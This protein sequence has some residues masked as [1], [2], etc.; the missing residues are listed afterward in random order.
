VNF[1]IARIDDNATITMPANGKSVIYLVTTNKTNVTITLPPAASAAGRFVI[2]KRADRGRVVL[3]R[4]N[5][6]ETIEASKATLRMENQRDSLTFV[7]DG[8]EWVLLSLI[9]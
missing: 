9:D 4:P 2:I 6:N 1:A 7:T 5:G 8:T 3:I